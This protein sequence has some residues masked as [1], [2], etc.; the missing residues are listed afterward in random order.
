MQGISNDGTPEDRSAL[1]DQLASFGKKV[2]QSDDNTDYLVLMNVAYK[3]DY[4]AFPVDNRN[5]HRVFRT[6]ANKP[7]FFVFFGQVTANDNWTNMSAEG[8]HHRGFN[9][10]RKLIEDSVVQKIKNPFGLECPMLGNDKIHKHFEMQVQSLVNMLDTEKA[11]RPNVGYELDVTECVKPHH[12][13]RKDKTAIPCI[14]YCLLQQK[15]VIPQAGGSS[16]S[17]SQGRRVVNIKKEKE[18]PDPNTKDIDD[19]PVPELGK[20]YDPSLQI[21]YG[22]NLFR[23]HHARLAQQPVYDTQNK[24][25]PS[26]ELWKHL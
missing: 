6:A 8:N 23:L 17:A 5:D 12:K 9:E 22:G 15:Y 3:E 16:N 21:D 24:L 20:T 25:V 13:D 26:W 18:T 14:I 19:T 1:I 11:E 7:T 4:H 2:P 10:P